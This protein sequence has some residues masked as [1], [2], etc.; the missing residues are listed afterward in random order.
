MRKFLSVLATAIL[1]LQSMGTSLVYAID[2]VDRNEGWESTPAVDTVVEESAPEADSADDA[3]AIEE[4]VTEVAEPEV[5]EEAAPAEEYAEET[6]TST[7][8][9]EPTDETSAEYAEEIV[10]EPTEELVEIVDSVEKPEAPVVEEPKA[11]EPTPA[12]APVED[13]AP[14]EEVSEEA[15]E[16]SYGKAFTKE[17]SWTRYSTNGLEV[18]AIDSLWAFPAGTEMVVTA[19][20]EE[21]IFDLVSDAI[22]ANVTKV[23]AVDITFWYNGEEKQPEQPINV[24]IKTYNMAEP[25]AVVHIDAEYNDEKI[26]VWEADVEEISA[27]IN[28]RTAE[29]EAE[30][31]SIYAF[32]E[33]AVLSVNF[34]DWTDVI[35][36]IYLKNVTEVDNLVFDPGIWETTDWKVFRGWAT[37][38]DYTA[39]TEWMTIEWVKAYLKKNF[40]NLWDTVTF[41]ARIFTQY[42]VTYLDENWSVI[43]TEEILSLNWGEQPYKVNASYTP[44]SPDQKFDGWKIESGEVADGE[45][46]YESDDN[47]YIC[48]NFANVTI[49]K[50]LTFKAYILEWHWLIFDENMKWATYVAPQFVETEDVTR[51]PS[52]YNPPIEMKKLGY[53]FNWWYKESEC[54]NAFSFGY[55]I[56]TGTTV[57]A[58]W[59]PES[60]VNY[61]VIIWKQDVAWNWYDFVKSIPFKGSVGEIIGIVSSWNANG[62]RIDGESYSYQG[63]HLG[64][65]D[66]NVE[67]KAEWNSVVNVYFNR[68]TIT[69]NFYIYSNTEWYVESNSKN[70]GNRYI[71]DGNWWYTQVYLYINDNRWYRN[72]EC[73]EQGW[74]GSCRRYAYSDEYVGKIYTKTSGS[75]WNLYQ[76][77]VWLYGQTLVQNQYTWPTEYDWYDGHD[78][79]NNGNITA[80]SHARTT[81]LD[82]FIIPNWDNSEDFY[83]IVAQNGNSI[84]EFYKQTPSKDGYELA[85]TVSSTSNGGNPSFSITDK[86]N[87]FR[88]DHYEIDGQ[89]YQLGEKDNN[90]YYATS[91]SY[92]NK[93]LRIYFNREAYTINF[94]DWAYVNGDWSP[95]E[96]INRG[97]LYEKDNITYGS[98]IS[99]YN[100]SPEDIPAWYVFEGR[101]LDDKGQ[102]EYIFDKMPEWGLTVYAKWRQKQYR[103]FLHPNAI[104]DDGEND[105]TLDWGSDKQAMNFRISYWGTISAPN[106]RRSDYEFIWRFTDESCTK[107]FNFGTQLT[108][109]TVNAYYDKETDFTD[110]MNKRWNLSWDE[111]GWYNSDA[112]WYSGDDRFWITTKLD[113]YGKWRSKLEWANGIR[114]VYNAVDGEYDYT[115]TTLYADWAEVVAWPASTPTDDEQQFKYWVVQTWDED[116]K[117]Y[118]DEI[119]EIKVYPGATFEVLKAKAKMEVIEWADEEETQIKTATY[120]VQLRAE[121]GPI[122]KPATTMIKYCPEEVDNTDCR[123]SEII[124]VN[125]AYIILWNDYFNFSKGSW[126]VF[127][128]WKGGNGSGYVSG[129]KVRV[130]NVNSWTLNILYAQ[131]NCNTNYHS[132]DEVTCVSNT[133]PE[134]CTTWEVAHGHYVE[135]WVTA[136]WS[137]GWNIPACTEI[138]CD[139]GY[140]LSGTTCETNT[141]TWTDC[142]AFNIANADPVI[143]TFTSVWS[144][145]SYTT[146][147][148]W[149]MSGEACT[150]A[151]KSWFHTEDGVTCVSNTNI[152][153]CTKWKVANATYTVTWVDVTWNEKEN[154]W[155]ET[156]ECAFKCNN[157]YHLNANKDGCE[158]DSTWWGGGWGSWGSHPDDC[159]NGDLSGDRYDGTCDAPG[160]GWSDEEEIELGW[161]V[162][163]KCSVEWSDRSEE[164]I[165]AY[166]Y[167][168]END[169]TTIRD[170]NE[171]RLG[172][173]LNRAEMAKI[174]SVFATKELWMKPN[175]SKDC[176]NFA[177]S[178]EGWSQEMKDYMVMSCQ[179]ELM[180]IHTVNYEAIPDFMPSKRVSRAEFWTILSRVLWWNTYEG[181]NENYYFRHLDALKANNIIT[182]IDPNI[183]E[184]RAWVLLMVYRSVE[185]IKSGRAT[186]KTSVEEQVNEEL[187][188]EANAGTWTVVEV[189]TGSVA[190]VE[191]WSVAEVETWN[192]VEEPTTQE[193]ET[194][195][196]DEEPSAEATTGDVVEG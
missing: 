50:D 128:W 141:L 9:E 115:D 34:N 113:L 23:R 37:G 170:I 8:D 22:D 60:N 38:A 178:M 196:S 12:A 33:T 82:A 175:T 147:P 109:E 87:W 127:S 192:V 179:L 51:D 17:Q 15:E 144:W 59:T 112:I 11:A 96:E 154:K 149:S 7:V 110:P 28:G 72:R 65:F 95:I 13:V 190:E 155:N 52:G 80:T 160:G 103:V 137:G 56:E 58:K 169:I 104:L 120:T 107:P 89:T 10:A 78:S 145:D 24:T 129:D 74:F 90:G 16:V 46:R 105:S 47:I 131:W 171:A 85:N 146:A 86:Y 92:G 189:A 123:D 43:K 99:T 116:S 152:V 62:V 102:H 124:I 4:T 163:D 54:I 184:Y 117:E 174:I 93:T 18:T 75:S 27:D 194:T 32:V 173:Y 29:F 69:F 25:Q 44:K 139:G 140:H 91:I 111:A 185:V 97:H 6:K 121:Y 84:V 1:V 61:N 106:W 122:A 21:H 114:I 151:C 30:S 76:S 3:P 20:D 67:I 88:A 79:N 42:T 181:T 57:Y 134:T 45:C 36:W 40:T 101:Y 108:D 156:P 157:G 195:V 193:W 167:A 98:D 48:Q 81:F 94:M 71:P 135:T 83:W 180:W 159:P 70:S 119:P 31:F 186:P 19:V 136:T 176:S 177:A 138:E 41:Y 150:Y 166:L 125:D 162:S 66:E 64:R 191:T 148:A 161:Q 153:D 133:K 100:I 130:D 35:T 55:K 187:K 68:N 182:N 53:V 142:G 26:E 5:L 143:S 2:P 77:M 168:C 63:F 73:V 188:E 39:E 158:K 14:I 183:T 126:Y 172:D 165:A 118:V 49:E 164:E 132:E